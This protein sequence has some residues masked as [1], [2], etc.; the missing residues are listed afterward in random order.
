M[1]T[2]NNGVVR[3]QWLLGAAAVALILAIGYS[4]IQANGTAPVAKM[5]AK[6]GTI[7][8]QPQ[9]IETLQ[10]RAQASPGDGN[11]WATL[12]DALFTKGRFDE[13]VVALEK[14]SVAAP[15]RADIWSA[16]GEARVMASPRDPMPPAA[17]T[18][19]RKA[20]TIDPKDPRSRY[21]TAVARDLSGDHQGAIN[22][23]LALLKDTPPGATWEN[24]LRRTITQVAKIN[25]I[26]VT[27]PLAKLAPAAS[28]PTM[29]GALAGGA[30]IPGPSPEQMRAAAALTPSQQ[31]MMAQQ[32][33]GQLEAKLRANPG[34]I[35]GWVMLMRSRK[36]LGEN[37]KASRALA[38]AIAANPAAAAR[39]Q[40]EAAAL[41]IAKL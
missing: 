3:G 37:A 40:S 23:W 30:A 36:T 9:P 16:L 21:F 5:A 22:D 6:T 38:D 29:A 12:G 14:G 31:D 1:N 10:A 24:D 27:A 7:A 4:M 32:M 11:A 34:N 2:K 26:D 25:K 15:G 41:G 39:L 18:A 35:D 17:L 8:T 13:A 33:V 20:L 19:F 28:H